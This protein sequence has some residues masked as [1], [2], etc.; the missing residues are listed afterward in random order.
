MGTGNLIPVYS[1]NTAFLG[2]ANTVDSE[3]K[4]IAVANFYR[5]ALPVAD[6]MEFLASRGIDYVMYGPEERDIAGGVEL[7]TLY[8]ALTKV[9]E[10]GFY[11]IYRVN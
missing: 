6:E 3:T 2:H 11:Q 7:P 5:Q 8:P 4:E 9:Y 1:G 10:N